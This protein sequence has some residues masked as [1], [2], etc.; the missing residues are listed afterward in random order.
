MLSDASLRA[1]NANPSLTL[2]K[3]S[4]MMESHREQESHGI[5]KLSAGYWVQSAECKRSSLKIPLR[6]L[7]GAHIPIEKLGKELFR[8]FFVLT[9]F[10]VELEVVIHQIL[11]GIL[12]HLSESGL[13]G[14]PR[15]VV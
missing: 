12:C 11:K 5:Q 14:I 7:A 2:P 4:T 3:N 15:A 8:D 13:D 9:D 6:L 10:L 1:G